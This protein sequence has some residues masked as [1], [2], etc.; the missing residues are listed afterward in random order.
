MAQ[1]THFAL[2]DEQR[3]KLLNLA[4]DEDRIDYVIE[5]I[6]EE[7]D[8]E[9]TQETDKAWDAIHRSLTEQPPNT[10]ELDAE[11][12]EYPLKLCILG[13]RP[14]VPNEAATIRLIEANEVSD[15]ARAL[16]PITKEWLAEKYWTHCKGAW[17]EYGEEDLEYTWDWFCKLREFFRRAAKAQRCVISTVF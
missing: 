8:E 17:P 9:F 4:S 1:G 15:L 12:G 14:L 7:W 5:D 13:G 3:E 6:E 10:P 16:D 11:C 2:T